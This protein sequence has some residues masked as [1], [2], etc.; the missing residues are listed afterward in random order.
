VQ[1]RPIQYKAAVRIQAAVRGWITR[2]NLRF[3][4]QFY[5]V[6]WQMQ[7]LK[8]ALG[9]HEI[10]RIL[11]IQAL[12]RGY[13]VRRQVRA[14]REEQRAKKEAE[15]ALEHEKMLSKK[16]ANRMSFIAMPKGGGGKRQSLHVGVRGKLGNRRHSEMGAHMSDAAAAA[17]AVAAMV[18]LKPLVRSRSKLISPPESEDSDSDSDSDTSSG[19]QFADYC[20][21]RPEFQGR[22]VSPL[23]KRL[24]ERTLDRDMARMGGLPPKATSRSP[25]KHGAATEDNDE[26]L[27]GGHNFRV[28]SFEL[29]Q[30]SSLAQGRVEDG[31]VACSLEVSMQ[32]R[33]QP[34]FST[35]PMAAV[36]EVHHSQ[37]YSPDPEMAMSSGG[38]DAS[39]DSAC[40][41]HGSPV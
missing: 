19:E 15:A 24:K 35:Q 5:S 34:N 6:V 10:D 3:R 17:A 16:K 25:A 41:G 13:M 8:I 28:G 21:S 11:A 1:V 18:E 32:R 39:A 37:S 31:L 14:L 29:P 4:K 30:A 38:T 22:S 40:L 9:G 23:A 33:R 2:S 27:L 12:I 36:P 20:S 26:S 7:C